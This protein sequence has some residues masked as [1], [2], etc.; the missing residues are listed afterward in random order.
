MKVVNEHKQ[1]F[2]SGD[3]DDELG[4]IHEAAETTSSDLS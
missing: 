1:S 2:R 3:D 4:P